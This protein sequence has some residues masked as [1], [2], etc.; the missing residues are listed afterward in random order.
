[1][2]PKGKSRSPSLPI[3][4]RYGSLFPANTLEGIP[5][6]KQSFSAFLLNHY[7][8]P[9]FTFNQFYEI[10]NAIIP[11]WTSHA[12]LLF[13]MQFATPNL[14]GALLIVLAVAYV[15]QASV[16][17]KRLSEELEIYMSGGNVIEPNSVILPLCFDAVG[18]GPIS[19]PYKETRGSLTLSVGFMR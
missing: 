4:C 8:D 15:G 3:C 1:L 18:S 14:V 11:N 16:Y 12:L 7:N 6:G 17:H 10:R 2:K 5:F 9:D 19:P 13:F